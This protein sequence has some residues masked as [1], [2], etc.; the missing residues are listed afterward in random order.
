MLTDPIADMLTR[1]RNANLA[2]RREIARTRTVTRQAEIAFGAGDL[3]V[4]VEAHR[5]QEK[6]ASCGKEERWTKQD[7]LRAQLVRFN[8]MRLRAQVQVSPCCRRDA[9][10]SRSAASSSPST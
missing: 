7:R 6:V 8:A 9:R 2:L 10:R 4:A 5:L 1:I 3:A